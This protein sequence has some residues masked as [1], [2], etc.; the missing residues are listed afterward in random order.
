M[1]RILL[2]SRRTIIELC[3]KSV[4]KRELRWQKVNAKEK[5]KKTPAERKNII[6]SSSAIDMRRS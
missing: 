5:R 2:E 6:K 1:C 3:G 4:L